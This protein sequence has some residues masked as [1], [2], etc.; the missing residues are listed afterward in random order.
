MTFILSNTRYSRDIYDGDTD[1]EYV[2]IVR[3]TCYMLTWNSYRSSPVK[4]QR[5]KRYISML[6]CIWHWLMTIRS[7][8]V[9][10][11]EEPLRAT[12]TASGRSSTRYVYY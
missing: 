7:L 6:H 5:Q 11:V 3:H 4:R 12:R 8:S 9:E 2:L 1:E 10:V